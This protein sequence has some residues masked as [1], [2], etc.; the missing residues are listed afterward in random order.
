MRI[1][2]LPQPE[3]VRLAS[4]PPGVPAEVD[5]RSTRSLKHLLERSCARFA[6][7]P[8][9]TSLGVSMSFR[10]L[11]EHSRAFGAFLQH[12]L[13]LVKG[14]RVAVM[15]PNTLQHPVAVMGALR[16]GMTVVN[17][18]PLYTAA[19]LRHQLQDS[20]TAAIVV[21]ENFAHTV[22]EALPGTPLRHV[23]V[24]QIGDLFPARKRWLVNFAVRHVKHAVPP[25][26]LDDAWSLRDALE[27]GTGDGLHEVDLGPDDVAFI[28]YTGGTTGRPK[29]AVLTH[30]NLV[31]NVEQVTAWIGALLKEGEETV[32]TALPL[33]HVFAL[34][35][36][37]LVFLRLGGHNVL[38]PDP[39][40]MKRFMAVLKRTP[41]TV[42]T[43]V[44]TLFNALMNASG[45]DEVAASRRGHVKIAVAGGMA[46]QGAVAERWRQAMGQPVVEGYG[47]S[48]TSP[49]VC[50]NR[51]DT[52]AFS[53]KL[54]L[55]VPSTEVAILDDD[56]VPQPLGSTGE[57]GVRGPQVMRGY[58]NKPEETAEV[59]TPDGWLRT[60][61]IGR[62]GPDGYVEFV[63][64]KKDIIVVSGMKAFPQEIDEAVRLH[65]D[66]EDAAAVGV[67]DEHSGEAVMLFVVR[68][69]P[70]LTGDAVR[71]HCEQHLAPYK[72]PRRIEFRQDLPRTPIG[73]VLRRQLKDEA[74][75]SAAAEV[76]A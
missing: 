55:P 51:V 35:A 57:I 42:I 15:L 28:Q 32:V 23:V 7:R 4:Y 74:I 20:G 37:L 39:R 66:V 33:Y 18:N 10:E 17:V 61:D 59:I 40:D 6:D 19:E 26:A 69:D 60:G 1:D 64:R 9:F 25:F 44:N 62:M 47:L 11:D 29:G 63:D 41:F 48:E 5:W 53:G 50:A 38:I 13:G 22:Q 67:P 68:R 45:F 2:A 14:E 54:G 75:K 70:A 71:R 49:I 30:G 27:R 36:N 56:G 52:M 76:R 58:W 34:T 8:A 65:P 43:G 16:A 24:T 72:R 31:A 46:L 73:K 21:L 3:R 12:D